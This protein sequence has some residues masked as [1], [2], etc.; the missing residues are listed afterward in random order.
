MD[1]TRLVIIAANSVM[2]LEILRD[3]DG[4]RMEFLD[5]DVIV[6]VIIELDLLHCSPPYLLWWKEIE[7]RKNKEK[8]KNIV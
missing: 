4:M 6:M 2:V 8:K 1:Y 5:M 3:W 7:K